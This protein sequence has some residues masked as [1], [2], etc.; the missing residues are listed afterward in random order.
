M[1]DTCTCL[2]CGYEWKK[3][4]SGDH[5][6]VDNLLKQIDKLKEQIPMKSWAFHRPYCNPASGIIQ[7]KTADEAIDLIHNAYGFASN[8]S[9][10]CSETKER[11]SDK[12]EF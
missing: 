11:K 7:A 12:S 2:T 4:V 6:C 9:V 10:Y 8:T 5:S 1:T 3:G